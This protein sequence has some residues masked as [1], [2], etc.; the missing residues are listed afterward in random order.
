MRHKK[1]CIKKKRIN[2]TAHR[3]K[4]VVEYDLFKFSFSKEL[5]EGKNKVFE[6]IQE[7]KRK[8]ASVPLQIDVDSIADNETIFKHK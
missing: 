6:C 5:K 2:S 1:S 4:I 7:L 8:N 3:T